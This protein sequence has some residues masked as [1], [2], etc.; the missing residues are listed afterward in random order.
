MMA[1]TVGALVSSVLGA[2]HIYFEGDSSYV[3]GLFDGVYWPSDTFFYNCLEISK[4]LL[5]PA[6]FSATWIPRALNS[7]CDSLAR[8]AVS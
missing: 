3:C 1:A 7:L 8:K 2:S 4:D 5:A 6:F